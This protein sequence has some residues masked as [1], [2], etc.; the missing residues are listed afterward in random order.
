[1]AWWDFIVDTA[2]A[3][4]GFV[5]DHAPDILNAAITIGSLIRS[6]TENILPDL[7]QAVENA[8][9]KLKDLVELDPDLQRPESK[10]TVSGPFDLVALWPSPP[11]SNSPVVPPLVS[12]DI[13]K[14]LTL[15]GVTTFLG[16]GKDAIDVG[17]HIAQQIF[18]TSKGKMI[19]LGD[20]KHYKELFDIKNLETGDEIK[21]GHIFYKIPLGN[22]G[23]DDAYHSHLRVW[24]VVPEGSRAHSRHEKNGLTAPKPAKDLSISGSY[25]STTLSVVW[26]LSGAVVAL[27][28]KAVDRLLAQYGDKLQLKVTSATGD[29]YSYQFWSEPEIGPGELA[30]GLSGAIK[31]EISDSK[32]TLTQ[33]PQVTITQKA[34]YVGGS[35]KKTT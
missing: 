24:D 1:M 27:M 6:P 25:N 3:I 10:E 33:L 32:G 14:F 9:E 35:T 2:G 34:T 12:S 19:P 20:N 26:T 15:N 13:N 28:P 4:G 7:V 21:G 29:G 30:S 23:L 31:A 5:V 22:E 11:A 17:Q 16:E 18:S 8:Q